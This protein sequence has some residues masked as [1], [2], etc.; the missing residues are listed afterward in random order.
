MDIK[1]IVYSVK[2]KKAGSL[3]WKTIRNVISDEA[4]GNSLWSFI[5]DNYEEIV[6]PTN[7]TEFVFSK[8]RHEL[9][10]SID[11]AKSVA[12]QSE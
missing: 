6:I 10:L 8:E 3:F 7:G 11:K 5:T 4:Y 1:K 12:D 9:I 2:Y